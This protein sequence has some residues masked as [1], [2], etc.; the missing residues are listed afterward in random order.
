MDYTTYSNHLDDPY[1]F[2][3]TF[4]YPVSHQ[5]N[6]GELDEHGNMDWV[7]GREVQ[8]LPELPIGEAYIT[9]APNASSPNAPLPV[10]GTEVGDVSMVQ[11]T[12]TRKKKAKTLKAKDWEPHKSYIK[13]L[14]IDEGLPLREVMDI[15]KQEFG[16]QPTYVI[17]RCWQIH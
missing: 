6:F 10:D 7:S 12:H 1:A 5:T 2:N 4:L 9:A 14:S 13:Q 16:F 8:D 17:V 3:E 15:M 11:S